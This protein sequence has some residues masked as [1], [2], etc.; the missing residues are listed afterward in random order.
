MNYMMEQAL[1]SSSL[2]MLLTGSEPRWG[3]G[4]WPCLSPL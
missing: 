1:T 3:S 4:R 2:N